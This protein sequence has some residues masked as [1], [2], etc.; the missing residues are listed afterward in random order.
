MWWTAL[1]G[2]VEHAR[3]LDPAV[4]ALSGAVNAV[5]PAGPVKDG[6][7]GR[8]LGHPLHPL[9]VTLPI[10]SWLGASLLDLAGG[11]AGRRAAQRLVGVGVLAVAPTAAAGTA[12]WSELGTSPRAKRVG[13]VHAAANYAAALVYGASWLARRRGDHRR[14]RNLALAGSAGL[15]VGGYLGGHL[16]YSSGVGVN[17]NADVPETPTAWTDVVAIG[18]LAEDAPR[19]F[20]VDGQPVVLVRT[21]GETFALGATCSH[22]GGPLADGAVDDGCLVCPWHSSRFR[23]RDGGVDRG[24]ATVPQ[25]AFDVRI[26]AERVQVRFRP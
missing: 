19:R 3:A 18:D 4:E 21:G 16:T 12:D 23:L 11:P 8:W 20:D 13:L 10:G 22:L 1:A 9:L 25:P 24:P 15:M 14:G 26:V 7:H 6:L 17:R 2:K 5:V